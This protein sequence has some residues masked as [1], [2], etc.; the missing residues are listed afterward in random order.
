M[1]RRAAG[2]PGRVAYLLVLRA[3]LAERGNVGS[4]HVPAAVLAAEAEDGQRH[5]S[6][7][8]PLRSLH[9]AA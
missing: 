3:P 9:G 6:D 5:I 2:L 8:A 7:S 4:E 1:R